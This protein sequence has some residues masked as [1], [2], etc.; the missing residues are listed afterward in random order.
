M[1]TEN[2]TTQKQRQAYVS[3]TLNA[4]HKGRSVLTD[5]RIMKKLYETLDIIAKAECLAV[6]TAFYD[7]K[8]PREIRDLVY[9]H[10]VCDLSEGMVRIGYSR[11][12][13]YFDYDDFDDEHGYYGE[14]KDMQPSSYAMN[15]A[16]VG[17]EMAKEIAAVYWS[18]NSFMFTTQNELRHA[19]TTD[20]FGLD[21]SPFDH[22][23]EF[24]VQVEHHFNANPPPDEESWLH[25]RFDALQTM[26]M[27]KKKDL[28]KV[29]I[30]LSTDFD[31]PA[32]IED[33]R[34]MFNLLEMLR[35]PVYELLH[36]GSEVRIE[37]YNGEEDSLQEDVGD[38]FLTIYSRSW[39]KENKPELD[40]FQMSA[41]EWEK[42]RRF[43]MTTDIRSYQCAG[44]SQCRRVEPNGEL[45][46][47]EVCWR[48][49]SRI[50]A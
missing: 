19:L 42:V 41:E 50:E 35:Y 36:A 20:H 46:F 47:R 2:V 18:K 30:R 22:I 48:R 29:E 45:Y 4:S 6:A 27:V 40:F 43:Y 5:R 1:A 3:I 26:C 10:L 7:R 21:V 49:G 23:R 12:P 25:K 37:Q 32:D 11:A 9:F 31:D 13:S 15:P 38:R 33:E 16:F 14:S 28:L 8:L 24:V 44:E 34:C 17:M 39:R